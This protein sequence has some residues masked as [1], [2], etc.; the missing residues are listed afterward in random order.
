MRVP[1]VLLVASL[2]ACGT[3]RRDQPSPSSSQNRTMGLSITSNAFASNAEIPRKYTCEG[4]DT[5]PQLAWSGAPANTKSVALIVDD[6]DA[7]DPKAPKMTYVHWVLYDIPASV[8]TLEASASTRLP[9]GIR[10]GLNDRK[11]TG[12]GG[13]CPPIG[14]HL[15]SFKLYALHSSLGH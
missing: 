6:P 5:S 12:R 15:Q 1:I 8:T 10:E 3:D 7:P 9:S 2:S 4:A 11:P 14:R 13:P